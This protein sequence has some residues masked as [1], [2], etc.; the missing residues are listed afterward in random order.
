MAG[1]LRALDPEGRR[2]LIYLSLKEGDGTAVDG[3][4]RR[5]YFWHD[6]AIRRLL[7]GMGLRLLEFQRSLSADGRGAVWLGY[8]LHCPA[9]GCAP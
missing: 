2:R 1:I 8:G 4:G 7:N 5:F 6:A 3:R 9:R